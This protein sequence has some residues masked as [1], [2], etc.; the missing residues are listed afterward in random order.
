MRHAE[1]F[2]VYLET[3]RKERPESDAFDELPQLNSLHLNL[4]TVHC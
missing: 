3:Y 2:E 4:K 1:E